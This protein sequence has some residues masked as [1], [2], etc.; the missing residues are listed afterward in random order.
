M[1]LYKIALCFILN[2]DK[3]LGFILDD[4][5]D[6]GMPKV[7]SLPDLACP[8]LLI[9]SFNIQVFGQS[10][11]KDPF[12]MDALTKILSRYHIVQILEIRDSTH[13][14]F[15]GLRVALNNYIRLHGQTDVYQKVESE[16]LGRTSSK[17]QYGFLYRTS[18]VTVTDTYQFQDTHDYFE[19]PPFGVKF[20]SLTTVIQDFGMI[21]SH[22]Q[23]SNAAVEINNLMPVYESFQRHWGISDII[24]GGDFNADCSYLS[25][26][27][28]TSIS[29]R[30][31]QRF[32][33]VVED[34]VDTTVA[35]SSCSYDRFVVAGSSLQQAIIPGSVKAYRFEDQFGLN[36]TMAT[37]ISDHYPI[38]IQLNGNLHL[39][40]QQHIQTSISF[41]V[42]DNKPTNVS[43]IRNIYHTPP[44]AGSTFTVKVSMDDTRMDFVTVTVNNTDTIQVMTSLFNFL[45]NCPGTLSLELLSTVKAYITSTFLTHS[46]PN[47]YGL[48]YST[49][50]NIYQ[51]KVQC[52]LASPYVCDVT[53][54]RQVS[55][56]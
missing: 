48:V 42:K 49:N 52:R 7:V 47:V 23:P 38:E 55:G 31:D 13:T 56:S 24:I 44:C 21:A 4:P 2:C 6:H 29:L 41:T 46:L 51:T 17:E 20:K 1:L 19:R 27:D 5:N 26:S 25:P 54:S 35:E 14:V 9:G 37:K 22:I 43:N 32:T 36:K 12:V 33:W 11:F 34:N 18:L 45:L 30:N 3:A 50:P 39:A 15:E 10:K 8:P 40:T 53:V 28:W 16:R